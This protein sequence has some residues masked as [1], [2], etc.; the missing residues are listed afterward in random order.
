M[1]KKEK[2]ENA[3]ASSAN[4][5][6]KGL[7]TRLRHII[8]AAHKRKIISKYNDDDDDVVTVSNRIQLRTSNTRTGKEKEE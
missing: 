5:W 4:E 1:K 6:Q 2:K 7:W 8:P 3:R